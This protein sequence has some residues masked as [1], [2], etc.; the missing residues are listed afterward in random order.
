MKR[1]ITNQLIF[2][3][4]FKLVFPSIMLSLCP[5]LGGWSRRVKDWGDLA[6]KVAASDSLILKKLV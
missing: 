6:W 1:N 2:I 5:K 3:T 4:A